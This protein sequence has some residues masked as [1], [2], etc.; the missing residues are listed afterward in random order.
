MLLAFWLHAASEG[1]ARAARRFARV[2][3]DAAEF[4][5]LGSGALSGSSLPLDRAAAALEL[6]FDAPSRNALDTVGDRDV[7]LDLLDAVARAL[8][9]ASRPERRVRDLVDARVRLRAARRR[10]LNRLEPDAAEDA[11]PIRS[12]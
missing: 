10:S 3:H 1:F 8:I 9:A 7:A 5:P 11:I 4:S 2:V 6:G 12:S